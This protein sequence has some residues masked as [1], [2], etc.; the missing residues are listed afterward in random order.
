MVFKKSDSSSDIPL[1][2]D[3]WN[4]ADGYSKLKILKHLIYLDRWE[5][6]SEFGSEEIDEA[7]LMTEKQIQKRRVEALQRF[8]SALKQLMGN[9]KF[10]L[11]KTDQKVIDDLMKRLDVVEEYIHKIYSVDED[12]LDGEVFEINEELFLKIRKILKDIKDQLNT[13]LNNAG[14]IFKNT[15]E[16]NLDKIMEDIVQGG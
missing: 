16:I 11:K 12:D 6:I 3:A 4:V 15:E 9:V 5:T 8:Y 7:N 1:G 2:T 14:L 10:A 13:P